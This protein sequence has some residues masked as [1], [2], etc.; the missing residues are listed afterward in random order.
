MQK[1]RNESEKESAHR[2]G[3]ELRSEP[4]QRPFVLGNDQQPCSALIQPVKNAS[5]NPQP[6]QTETRRTLS[7]SAFCKQHCPGHACITEQVQVN[8]VLSWFVVTT[9]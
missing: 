3:L 2:V 5:M 7:L 8:L 9:L 6:Q 4:R 1:G